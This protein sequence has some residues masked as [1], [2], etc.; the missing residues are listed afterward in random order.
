MGDKTD[1]FENGMKEANLIRPDVLN[2]M[3]ENLDFDPDHMKDINS[4]LSA[5]SSNLK[6]K[7]KIKTNPVIKSYF[8]GIINVRL[9][10][11]NK[12]LYDKEGINNNDVETEFD[13]IMKDLKL[14]PSFIPKRINTYQNSDELQ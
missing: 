9:D 5:P 14:K 2:K 10:P 8:D 3:L 4:W 11:R 7:E 1:L 13:K 6:I 12:H